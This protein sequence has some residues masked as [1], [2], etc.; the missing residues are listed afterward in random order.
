[1]WEILWEFAARFLIVREIV[2]MLKHFLGKKRS[3]EEEE[4]DDVYYTGDI[5]RRA[6]RFRSSDNA[7]HVITLTEGDLF[8]LGFGLRGDT[9]LRKVEWQRVTT[10]E[11]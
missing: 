11:N 8:P 1:M 3:V 7:K 2:E 6:G 4:N 9:A 5:C 10:F